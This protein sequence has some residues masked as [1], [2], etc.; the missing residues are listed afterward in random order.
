MFPPRFYAL[1]LASFDHNYSQNLD[2]QQIYGGGFGYTALKT[3]KQEL[4]V[5]AT[6]QYER[7]AF[8]GTPETN[9]NLI[10]T[11]FGA[12]Y[13]ANLKFLTYTQGVAYVPAWNDLHA[14]SLNETNTLSFPT[15]KNL[16]FTVGTLDSYINN[17]PISEPPTKPNSFQFQMGFTYAIKSK[18]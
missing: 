10:S 6:I 9:D 8:M 17:P 4:D 13:Q 18:Y 1:V 3:P 2:L 12:S 14:Y 16:S 7:Q 15:Y 11:T 5:K